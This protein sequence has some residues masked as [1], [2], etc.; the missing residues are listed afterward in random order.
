MKIYSWCT[1]YNLLAHKLLDFKNNRKQLIDVIKSIFS[2]PDLKLPTLEK[3]NNI[4]DIDPFTVF[5]LF[6]KKIQE[7]NRKKIISALAKKLGITE[8]IPS[9]F[10]GIPVLNNFNA[11]FYGFINDRSVSDID[12][13]WQYLAYLFLT[14]SAVVLRGHIP[15]SP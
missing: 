15:E 7:T 3:D 13:L 14:G 9:D 11:T 4:I 6:N 8:T 2:E 10:S 5:G 1:F 12:D